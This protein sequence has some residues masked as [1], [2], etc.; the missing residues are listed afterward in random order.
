MATRS[1]IE[2]RNGELAVNASN[3]LRSDQSQAALAGKLGFS[4]LEWI[5]LNLSAALRN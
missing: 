1:F 2:N 3:P 5:R 4:G